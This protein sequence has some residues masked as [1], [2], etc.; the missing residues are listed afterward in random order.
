[1]K[2][3]VVHRYYQQASTKVAGGKGGSG[4][5]GQRKQT[6][7]NGPPAPPGLDVDSIMKN[8]QNGTSDRGRARSRQSNKRDIGTE[9]NDSPP[10]KKA[11]REPTAEEEQSVTSE[12]SNPSSPSNDT[13]GANSSAVVTPPNNEEFQ[14]LEAHQACLAELTTIQEG[15]DK[16]LKIKRRIRECVVQRVFSFAKYPNYSSEHSGGKVK[17]MARVTLESTVEKFDQ[18]WEPQGRQGIKAQLQLE[19]RHQRAAMN[20]KLKNRFGSE[21]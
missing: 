18:D 4:R 6:R 20:T 19:L 12:T 7:S 17:Q 8:V 16:K 10:T 1:M 9:S 5:G 21:C 2:P 3:I 14:T 11:T 15:G 13:R